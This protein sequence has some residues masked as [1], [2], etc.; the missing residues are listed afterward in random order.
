MGYNLLKTW[1]QVPDHRS[2]NTT[3]VIS[4][5]DILEKTATEKVGPQEKNSSLIST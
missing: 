5:K 2:G 3:I 1:T 4:R